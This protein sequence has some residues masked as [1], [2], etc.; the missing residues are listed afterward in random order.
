MSF[1]NLDRIRTIKK[2]A[3]GR[4]LAIPGVHAVGI[5]SKIVGGERTDEP[6]IM[7][8]VVKKK[9]ASELPAGH[10]IPREIEGVKTDVYESDVF[11]HIAEDEE[12]YRDPALV[13]GC[14]LMMGGA[15]GPVVI[16]HPPQPDTVFP[17][18]GLGGIGTLGCFAKTGGANPKAVAITCWHVLGSAN[19]ADPTQ[20]ILTSGIGGFTVAGTNT[21]G[22]LIVLS[23][24]VS[25]GDNSVFYVTTSSDTPATI[26]GALANRVNALGT[27]GL[28]ATVT[29]AQVK[30]VLSGSG[31]LSFQTYGPHVK[32][33]WASIHATVSGT[34]ISLTGQAKDACAA[35]VVLNTAGTQPTHGIFVPIAEGDNASKVATAIATAITARHLT[36]ITAI[37]MDPANPGDPAIVNISGVQAVDCDVSNDLRVGQPTNSFC[38]RCSKCCDDRIGTIVDAQLDVDCALIQL[39]PDY[40]QKYRAEVLD[41]GVIRGVH[42]ISGETSGY[43]LQK[44]GETTL[45]THGTLLAIDTDGDTETDD[46]NNPPTWQLYGR[47]YTGAFT[48]QGKSG[49][50]ADHGDSGSAVLTDNAPNSNQEIVGIL[51]G[52]SPTAGIATPIQQILSAFP[53]LN[54]SIETATTPGV[55]KTVPAASSAHAV[56]TDASANRITA[57][58]FFGKL[59]EIQ[60]RVTATNAGRRY[61][62]LIQKHFPELQRL[63]NNNRRVAAAWRRHGGPQIVRSVVRMADAPEPGI[64][65]EVNGKPLP[66]CLAG[67]QAAFARYASP[68]LAVDLA[69]YGPNLSQLAGLNYTQ[70]LDVLRN[71]KVD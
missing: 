64:P 55:D 36:G 32:N 30:I 2:A 29:G 71:M 23:M 68:D 37:E 47:H 6:S 41:I 60:Q 15:K 7:V 19:R 17:A 21:P 58:P 45:L 66:E 62:E 53:A 67:I 46:P 16:H 43:P 4:L 61:N 44:R 51:F 57:E 65:V 52:S 10:L 48:I 59:N 38:S 34:A 14:R 11:R 13:A 70:A 50:F 20:L 69:Q 22:T 12:K 25:T 26:A 24:G 18:E 8:F 3:Q 28:T 49:Q 40:V 9:P 35:F 1:K 54:L 39:N 63:V 42:D 27:A 31:T 33:T 5:G 56:Q